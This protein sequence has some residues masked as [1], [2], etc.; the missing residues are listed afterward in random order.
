MDNVLVSIII[1]VYN[2][3]NFLSKAIDSAL[4]QTYRNIEIIV[5]N[6]GS[7]DEGATEAIA[8][9]Y[10][11]S[12]HYFCKE[13]GGV[14]S[15]LNM[16]IEQMQGEYFSWLS[17][18]DEYMPDKIEKELHALFQYNDKRLV[19]LCRSKQID[20]N[21][22]LIRGS[23]SKV[24][25]PTNRIVQWDEALMA[26]INEK[27]FNGCA[28]LIPKVVFEECGRFHE[29]LRFS[30]DML[31]WMTMFINKYNLVMVNECLVLSRL[32]GGQLTQNGQEI[33]H[34]DC[35]AICD[36]MLARLCDLSS[37]HNNFIRCFAKY[38]AIYNNVVVA[39]KCINEGRKR[40]L[41]S[42][43]SRIGLYIMCIYGKIRPAIRQ[44]YYHI[45]KP[46]R[47]K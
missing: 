12:I 14:S 24:I 20:I 32:H 13:N 33:F 25:F 10:G 8:R 46:I 19:A 44:L 27:C 43:Y 6:D 15:A 16:G 45:L 30:Q 26:L 37:K 5:V 36:I 28:F 11:D 42:L 35:E 7:K 2:G 9:S 4:N 39:D 29:G 34:K 17:H 21:S 23:E 1:P 18:D 40:G 31:M 41:I 47:L 38:N 22:A 3:S